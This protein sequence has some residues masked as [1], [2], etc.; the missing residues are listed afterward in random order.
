MEARKSFDERKEM[1][2]EVEKRWGQGK[3]KEGREKSENGMKV[4]GFYKE[5]KKSGYKGDRPVPLH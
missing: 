4:V 2:E 1:L 5:E 3:V